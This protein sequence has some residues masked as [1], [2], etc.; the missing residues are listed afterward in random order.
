MS[1][2]FSGSLYNYQTIRYI[3]AVLV[4]STTMYRLHLTHTYIHTFETCMIVQVDTASYIICIAIALQTDSAL[5]T[6]SII[7]SQIRRL[8]TLFNQ[9]QGKFYL[10]FNVSCLFTTIRYIYIYNKAI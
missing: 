8:T 9:L 4:K 7:M 3:P 5:Y 6:Y 10:Q 2:H 1:C